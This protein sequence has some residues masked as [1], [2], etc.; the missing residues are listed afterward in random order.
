MGLLGLYGRTG[1]EKSLMD[2]VQKR[3]TFR[4]NQ[5]TTCIGETSELAQKQLCAQNENVVSF[6]TKTKLLVVTQVMCPKY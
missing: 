2:E 3:N 5:T 6:Q 1:M 4:H